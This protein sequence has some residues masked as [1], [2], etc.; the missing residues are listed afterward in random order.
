[1]LCWA[2]Q[3]REGGTKGVIGGM[4][5]GLEVLGVG[6]GWWGSCG[7]THAS[8]GYVALTHSPSFFYG[9]RCALSGAKGQDVTLTDAHA[10]MRAS[11]KR[12]TQPSG[13]HDGTDGFRE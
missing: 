8:R 4:Q 11:L 7:S 12:G 6:Y 13:T 1:M 9:A 3:G 5:V 2:R 10:G